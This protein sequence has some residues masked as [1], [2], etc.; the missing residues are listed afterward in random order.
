MIVTIPSKTVVVCDFCKRT[1]PVFDKCVRC[2]R[3]YCHTCEAIMCGC[4]HQPMICKDCGDKP[5][6]VKVVERFA[7]PLKALL[8]KRDAALRRAK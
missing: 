6:V 5:S 2:N 7:A 8:K 4:I 3:L 1:S